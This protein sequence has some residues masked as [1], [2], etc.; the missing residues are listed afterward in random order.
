MQTSGLVRRAQV[1]FEQRFGEDA[2][3]LERWQKLRMRKPMQRLF[4]KRN[5]LQHNASASGTRRRLMVEFLPCARTET[6]ISF[7]CVVYVK[8]NNNKRVV[9]MSL[10]NDG[11][12]KFHFNSKTLQ[13]LRMHSLQN[14]EEQFELCFYANAVLTRAGAC[15]SRRDFDALLLSKEPV[16]APPPQFFFKFDPHVKK[17]THLVCDTAGLPLCRIRVYVTRSSVFPSSTLPVRTLANAE[18]FANAKQVN[19]H[20]AF[21][22][23][24]ALRRTMQ[25]LQHECPFTPQHCGKFASALQLL[26]H[27]TFEHEFKTWTLNFNVDEYASS[28]GDIVQCF[29]ENKSVAM[30]PA[31]V[32]DSVVPRRY[33]H[34]TTLEPLFPAEMDCS[35]DQEEPEQDFWITEKAENL[36]HDFQ[37]ISQSDRDFMA[38]WN[39]YVLHEA[40]RCGNMYILTDCAVPRALLGFIE[41]N[42][43]VLREKMRDEFLVHLMHLWDA[44]VIKREVVES[45]IVHLDNL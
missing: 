38:M 18:I 6:Q 44:G 43:D 24:F 27:V 25:C 14:E 40:E 19:F 8:K 11:N 32:V 1:D 42:R 36:L 15:Y 5:F 9:I 16:C 45:M 3:R 10:N 35:S 20:F 28:A 22:P 30:M 4:L 34:S 23:K 13:L 29:V 12:G 21:G 41:L 17:Q 2:K 37:D 7:A 31:D 39:E 33:F 26:T